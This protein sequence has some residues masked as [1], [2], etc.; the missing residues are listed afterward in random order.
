VH[1][2]VSLFLYCV[3][4]SPVKFTFGIKAMCRLVI[5]LSRKIGLKIG[6]FMLLCQ[7]VLC[8]SQNGTHHVLW[9]LF[10]DVDYGL[11]IYA[12]VATSY[13]VLLVS[14]QSTNLV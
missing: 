9:I 10:C 3:S 1:V 13:F 4:P 7:I 2:V 11:D 14:S 6:G 8:P 12:Y 5:S